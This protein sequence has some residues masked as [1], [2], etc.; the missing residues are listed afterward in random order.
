MKNNQTKT[1][2]SARKVPK[3]QQQKRKKRDV[4]NKV[5]IPLFEAVSHDEI[6]LKSFAGETSTLLNALRNSWEMCKNCGQFYT[7][8]ESYEIQRSDGFC[9]S[10]VCKIK[11]EKYESVALPVERIN[12]YAQILSRE[13][14]TESLLYYLFF[15][16]DDLKLAENARLYLRE[17]SDEQKYD[18]KTKVSMELWRSIGLVWVK[19]SKG[20]KF[21][22]WK[23][24]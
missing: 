4:R 21:R 6:I 13:K 14:F 2:D 15:E 17:Q 23:S 20:G 12:I 8:Q 10:E 24:F 3:K 5:R 1:D 11:Y 22:T 7:P 19:R 18:E 16:I 9:P